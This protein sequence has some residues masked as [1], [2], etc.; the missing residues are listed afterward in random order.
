[1]VAHVL[2][3]PMAPTAAAVPLVG[4]EQIAIKVGFVHARTHVETHEMRC[5][6][7]LAL[8]CYCSVHWCTGDKV[9]CS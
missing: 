6:T 7:L 3:M 2:Q 5:I 1:M 8:L 9:C 4:L